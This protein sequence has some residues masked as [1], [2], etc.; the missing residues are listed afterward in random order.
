MAE[1]LR[2]EAVR[3]AEEGVNNYLYYFFGGVPFYNYS[4]MGPKPYSNYSGAYITYYNKAL[5]RGA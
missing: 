2:K 1:L 5:I 3:S 4:I